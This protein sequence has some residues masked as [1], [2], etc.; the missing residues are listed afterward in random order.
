MDTEDGIDEIQLE[1]SKLIGEIHLESHEF[2]KREQEIKKNF[3]FSFEFYE[4]NYGE[5][6]SDFQR[7]HLVGGFMESLYWELIEITQ[8]YSCAVAS[9]I[10]SKNIK[11]ETIK[12]HILFLH[13]NIHF[14]NFFHR[15][16]SFLEHIAIM[17]N[18]FS[19][20][21]YFQED[22]SV[23]LIRLQKKIES[24]IDSSVGFILPKDYEK[25]KKIISDDKIYFNIKKDKEQLKEFRRIIV[26]RFPVTPDS[27]CLTH[28]T[29]VNIDSGCLSS[30][31]KKAYKANNINSYIT[32]K[33]F[34]NFSYNKYIDLAY[35]LLNN[36]YSILND[37]SKLD[38]M[39]NI[40]KQK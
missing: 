6:E 10:I 33:H 13:R 11:N 40:I 15:W 25:I 1:I 26:H 22:N 35:S 30:E 12:N 39:K 18:N 34:P 20:L 29:R 32:Y 37:L 16:F 4:N 7:D 14:I 8:I 19:K 2:V 17:I 3:I 28:F 36:L 9:D 23:S 38:L 21:H 27:N 24:S 5:L 31:I